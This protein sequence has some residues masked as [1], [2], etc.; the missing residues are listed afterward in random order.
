[1]TQKAAHALHN[2]P[3]GLGIAAASCALAGRPEE[4]KSAAV[5]LRQLI[6]TLKPSDL[7][8]LFGFCRPEDRATFEEGLRK[9]G[10]PE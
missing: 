6:P 7:A 2:W 1:M 8:N 9:A 3:L 5:R 4:A 10:L